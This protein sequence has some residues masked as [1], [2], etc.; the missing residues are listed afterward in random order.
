MRGGLKMMGALDAHIWQLANGNDNN[1]TRRT[2]VG[3]L[4]R[5]ADQWQ[6]HA[7]DD[8]ISGAKFAQRTANSFMDRNSR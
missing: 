2:H 1:N 4:R 5:V 6:P 7:R 3:F 8:F